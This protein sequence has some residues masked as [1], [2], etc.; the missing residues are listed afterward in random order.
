MKTRFIFA[1]KAS[2][3]YNAV[4]SQYIMPTLDVLPEL[5]QPGKTTDHEIQAKIAELHIL[6]C[7]MHKE[8]KETMEEVTRDSARVFEEHLPEDQNVTA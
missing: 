1:S 5:G 6:R 2:D 7:K 8:L 3:V 4:S